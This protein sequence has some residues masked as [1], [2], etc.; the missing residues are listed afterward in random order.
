MTAWTLL[1]LP[2]ALALLYFGADLFVRAA[3]RLSARL[4]VPPLIIGLTVVAIGTSAPELLV[5]VQAAMQG[6]ADIAAGNVVGSNI[7]NILVILGI[8]ALITPLAVATRIVRLELPLLAV[9][10][11]VCMVLARDGVIG[12]RPAA[13]LILLLALYFAFLILAGRRELRRGRGAG[14]GHAAA[15]RSAKWAAVAWQ[16]FQLLGGLG[17]LLLGSRWLVASA[18]RIAQALGVSELVIGLT[19]VAAG[20]SLPEA[21][22][23]IL[24][25]VRKERDIA[26]GNIIGSNIFNI[27]GVMGVAGVAAPHGM[28]IAES[29]RRVDLP[30]SLLAAVV[31]LPIFITGGR[32]SRWEGALLLAGYLV[33]VTYLILRQ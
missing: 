14:D 32:I 8:S 33:Y 6:R 1:V 17:I 19:V 20:T 3:S 26:V 2:L 7:F 21:A 29:V 15:P 27:L 5:S 13:A 11:I 16:L 4:G 24:A 25:A 31:C 18:A 30:L 28:S 12:R 23:S 9:G 22:T 10:T